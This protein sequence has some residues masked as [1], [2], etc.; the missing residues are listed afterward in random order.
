MQHS[1]AH[2]KVR[3]TDMHFDLTAECL[4]MYMNQ[5]DAQNSYD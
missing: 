3:G 1:A 5:Q 2:L 4:D